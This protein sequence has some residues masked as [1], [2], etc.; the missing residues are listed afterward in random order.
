[1]H[2]YGNFSQ[3]LGKETLLLI[4]SHSHSRFSFDS[5]ADCEENILAAMARGLDGLAFTD[6]IDRLDG[7]L[8]YCFDFDDYIRT[9]IPLKARYTGRLRLL[10]GA[11]MGLNLTKNDWIEAAMKDDRFDYFI[12]SLHTVDNQDVASTLY[13]YKG[14]LKVFYRNYYDAMVHAATGTTGYHVLG[15]MDYLDRYVRDKAAIPP[16]AFYKEQVAAVLEHLIQKDLVLEYNTAGKYKGLNYGNPKE[17][18][19]AL[20][21][22]L[23]GKRICLSSDAHKSEHIGRDFHS[24]KDYLIRLGFTHATY[25]EKKCPVEVPLAD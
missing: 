19:L 11:E 12:G 16:F 6:H 23:G 1:M 15:H 9:L 24:A 20:Y 2:F 10:I 3:D 13:R 5:E 21:R 25:F 18:I 14:D 4:D 7:P 8:D 17:E 22:D